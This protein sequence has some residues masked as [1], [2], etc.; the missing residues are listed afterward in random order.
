MRIEFDRSRQEQADKRADDG[1][2]GQKFYQRKTAK[3]AEARGPRAA[4]GGQW[5][6]VVI[7]QRVYLVH[8]NNVFHA[9]PPAAAGTQ[10]VS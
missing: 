1:D 8:V 5:P 7:T 4:N 2:H 9:T 10:V 6:A 3:P